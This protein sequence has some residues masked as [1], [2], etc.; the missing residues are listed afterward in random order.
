MALL[1]TT[2]AWTVGA[3]TQGSTESSP[4]A[5]ALAR[6][7]V[8]DAGRKDFK[9]ALVNLQKARELAPREPDYVYEI[10]YV[11]WQSGHPDLAL[12]SFNQALVLNPNHIPA[13]LGRARLNSKD[14][15]RAKA[16]LD[17][18][19][20]VADPGDDARL[21]AGLMYEAIGE[22]APAIHQY[23]QWLATHE[24]NPRR[25]LA[26]DARCRASGE[27]NQDLDQAL[28]D[29]NDALQ[30]LA[31]T[32]N[33]ARPELSDQFI[34]VR[35]QP[36]PDI[37]GSRGLVWLRRGEYDRSIKDYDGAVDGRPK[38]SE[39]RFARGLAELRAGRKGKGQADI[40]AATAM[41]PDVAARFAAWGLK[42]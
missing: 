38:T 24:Q 36:N 1:M 32:T 33:V 8:E 14:P 9:D 28:K 13:L 10:G 35:A 34:H 4:E 3:E 26:L 12:Q 18:I 2:S 37:L 30:Q 27:A 20:R 23:D 16:D 42:P 22:L 7:G 29:C 25:V 31:S 17:T 15:A 5:A 21:D 41:Q 11:Q 39:Y 40:K 6:S 19:D